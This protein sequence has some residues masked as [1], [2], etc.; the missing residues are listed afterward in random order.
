MLLVHVVSHGVPGE[1]GGVA[2][3]R[4]VRTSNLQKFHTSLVFCDLGPGVNVG[5]VIVVVVG[6]FG[7]DARMFALSGVV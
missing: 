7:R 6:G 5:Y 3:K 1:R 2:L 4:I